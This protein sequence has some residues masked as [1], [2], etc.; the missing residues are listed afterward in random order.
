MSGAGTSVVVL[1]AAVLWLVY[2]V[3]T[4]FRRREYL[5]TELNAVRL[6]QT[7]R[8]LAETAEVPQAVRVESTAREIAAQQKHLRREFERREA[9][10]RAREASMNRAAARTL[11][12]LH[13]SVASAAMLH[14]RAARRLRRS[15][16]AT[17]LVLLLSLVVA[18]LGVTPLAGDLSAL[19]V[20]VGTVT[21]AAAIGMLTV[22]A[23]A[24]R[25]RVRLAARLREQSPALQPVE[26]ERDEVE[27]R[28]SEGWMPVPLPKPLYLGRPA[29]QPVVSQLALAQARARVLEEAAEAERLAIVAEQAEKVTAIVEG[30]AAV[31]RFARM[32]LLEQADGDTADSAGTVTTL[33][34][35]LRR[36]RAV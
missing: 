18:L 17:S 27:E 16:A 3:P 26:F 25:A 11:A 22:L 33:D 13:P 20:T 23:S 19:I 34:D 14:S 4:W 32:G 2:L 35:T 6:Q 28:R 31:S 15:R 24:G 12:T 36:R 30:P 8:I 29:P 9:V 21:A 1:L 5:S 7:L 10:A